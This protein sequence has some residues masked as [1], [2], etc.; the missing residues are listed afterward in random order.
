MFSVEPITVDIN[1]LESTPYP[2]KVKKIFN[3]EG[4]EDGEIY[5][6]YLITMT[7]DPQ[8]AIGNESIALQQFPFEAVVENL[9]EIDVTAP[10]LEYNERGGHDEYIR[11]K[12]EN[13]PE[14]E[15]LINSMDNA[16]KRFERKY[17][18]VDRINKK[19]Y[20]LTFPTGT[21]LSGKVLKC[22]VDAAKKNE[23]NLK[24]FGY[25]VFEEIPALNKS[26][27]MLKREFN[28]TTNTTEIHYG[29][30]VAV[31][32]KLYWRVA[33]EKHD[34]VLTGKS[35]VVKGRKGTKAA[36]ALFG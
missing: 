6:G 35:V 21:K 26:P 16:R 34:E 11:D 28:K 7:V 27:P 29:I 4:A 2:F 22:N 3:M 25:T 5:N 17:G 14:A 15:S 23:K 32:P 20:R 19:I 1:N 10:L 30:N 8:D 13:K 18:T 12:L 9:T 31:T 24:T 33:D 36:D